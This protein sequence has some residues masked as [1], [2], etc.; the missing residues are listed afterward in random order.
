MPLAYSTAVKPPRYCPTWYFRSPSDSLKKPRVQEIGVCSEVV[1]RGGVRPLVSLRRQC[2][3]RRRPAAADNRCSELAPHR[4]CLRFIRSLGRAYLGI[5]GG[6]GV[7]SSQW[8]LEASGRTSSTPTVSFSVAR[9]ASTTR[10]VKFCF[11][12]EG[13]VDWSSLNGGTAG[14]AV[15]AAGAGA[16]CETKNSFLGTARARVGYVADRTLFYV[17]G[18]AACRHCANRMDSADDIRFHDARGLGRWHRIRVRLLGQLECQGRIS[19]RRF[20]RGFLHDGGKL[21]KRH[22]GIRR[23]HRKFVRVGIN[24]IFPIQ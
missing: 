7:G 24:Y 2:G 3:A 18:G 8:T 14:C 17:T 23:S 4:Q 19:L 16:A 20:W 5:N 10:S 22:G 15:N 9:S 11:G 13:D 21:R 12:L 6:Y 1:R